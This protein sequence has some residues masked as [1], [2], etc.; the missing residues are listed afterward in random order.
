M[1]KNLKMVICCSLISLFSLSA[2]VYHHTLLKGDHTHKEVT[3]TYHWEVVANNDFDELL[4][5]WD[6]ARPVKGNYKI[7]VSVK[8]DEWSPWLLYAQ[9]GKEDQK[10]F[11]SEVKG[12]VVRVYQ[13]AVE[14]LEG[15]KGKEFKIR[16]VGEE[17]TSLSDFAALHVSAS[18][19]SKFN[20]NHLLKEPSSVTVPVKGL[21]QMALQDSRNERL[22]SPTSTTAVVRYLKN[23][24]SLNPIQFA[25]HVWDGQFD[26]FGNWVFNTAQASAELGSN[27]SC[28]VA[29]LSGF[30]EI[31][32]SLKE[33]MPVVISI[34]GPLNGS[35]KPY[36]S[37]HLIVVKGYDH[38]KKEV[39]CMDPA[40]ES[41]N[42]TDVRYSL[43]DLIQAWERR[44]CIAYLFKKSAPI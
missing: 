32:T 20:P 29:R 43:D 35:A 33:G 12:S 24:D 23:N 34:R 14:V 42:K 4:I 3:S 26:M 10:G 39:L 17:G 30:N 31:L 19:M 22:C 8:V 28:W 6:A 41:D 9:W 7:Y 18:D 27:W 36:S 1:L 2:E 11:L 5:S 25:E 21:S 38:D 40:F 16:V 15:K 13:D 44:K 37:G